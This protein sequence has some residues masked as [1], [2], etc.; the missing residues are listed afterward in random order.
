MREAPC[1]LPGL[2][3]SGI[4]QG[5]AFDPFFGDFLGSFFQD[6][7]NLLDLLASF[8]EILESLFL[9]FFCLRQTQ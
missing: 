6:L 2:P 1:G 9:S 8:C 7:L 5:A 3:A 4:V